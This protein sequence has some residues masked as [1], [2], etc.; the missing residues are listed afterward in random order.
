MQPSPRR[1][2]PRWMHPS[3]ACSGGATPAAS[4]L[5]HLPGRCGHPLSSLEPGSP[6]RHIPGDSRSVTRPTRRAAARGSWGGKGA[7]EGGAAARSRSPRRD[8]KR[9]ARLVPPVPTRPAGLEAPPACDPTPPRSQVSPA[10]AFLVVLGAARANL[11]APRPR[12]PK[13]AAGPGR[14]RGAARDHSPGRPGATVPPARC[15]RPIVGASAGDE[16]G[17]GWS[18]GEASAGRRLRESA[19]ASLGRLSRSGSG[20]APRLLAAFRA[21]GGRQAANGDP[22][23]GL[24]ARPTHLRAARPAGAAGSARARCSSPRGARGSPARSTARTPAHPTPHP[25]PTP[26]AEPARR[27]PCGRPTR[28]AATLPASAG[29]RRSASPSSCKCV[30]SAQRVPRTMLRTGKSETKIG[31]KKRLPSW[32]LH[33]G[34][35]DRQ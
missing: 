3:P 19:P 16:R 21:E 5:P 32:N 27:A 11:A 2:A 10:S 4:R 15:R 9:P 34:G 25:A 6:Q 13:Q 18:A 24:A 23:G 35:E 1:R 12:E 30:L 29:F 17:G 28:E 8:T 7:T 14:S 26:G 22:A 33:S 31:F 20:A